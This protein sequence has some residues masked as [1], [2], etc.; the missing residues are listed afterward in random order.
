MSVMFPQAP[1]NLST[2]LSRLHLRGHLP[3]ST[4]CLF[5]CFTA[6]LRL[7]DVKSCA[8]WITLCCIIIMLL[9]LTLLKWKI[10]LF[11]AIVFFYM[12]GERSEIKLYMRV[13]VNCFLLFDIRV[14]NIHLTGFLLVL[15]TEVWWSL[16]PCTRQVMLNNLHQIHFSSVYRF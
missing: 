14:W 12:G 13:K 5:Y 3:A 6:L 16:C 8:R 15:V 11:R 2:S 10:R 9:F 1:V 4:S 7:C